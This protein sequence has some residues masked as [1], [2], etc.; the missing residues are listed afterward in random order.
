MVGVNTNVVTAGLVTG[1]DANDG[2]FLTPLLDE[3]LE[4]FDVLEVSADKAYL[5]R[6]NLQDIHDRG[7]VG[8]IPFKSNSVVRPVKESLDVIWNRAFCFFQLYR[9][10]FLEHY[11][12]R[13]NVETTFSMIKMKFGAR[14]YSKTPVA[15][16]NEILMK[17]LCHNICVLIMASFEHGIDPLFGCVTTSSTSTDGVGDLFRQPT[18]MPTPRVY[19]N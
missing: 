3:T 11:H 15:Q 4:H 13:S 12:Q 19:P 17:F 2:P 8:Y 7:A 18:H 5:T 6:Q 16:T 1:P 10:D 14:V 9:Q